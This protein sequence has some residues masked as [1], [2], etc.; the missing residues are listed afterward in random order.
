MKNEND[1]LLRSG[2]SREL[3]KSTGDHENDG[4]VELHKDSYGKYLIKG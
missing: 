1:H 2:N 3:N 4:R